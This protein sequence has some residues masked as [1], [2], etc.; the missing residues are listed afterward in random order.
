MQT[1]VIADPDPDFLEWTAQQL[2]SATTRVLT[3]ERS[4]EA[5]RLCFEEGADLLIAELHLRPFSGMELL[6]KVKEKAF[7]S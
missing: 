4:D 5:F 7:S 1:I 2:K 3:T 6:I